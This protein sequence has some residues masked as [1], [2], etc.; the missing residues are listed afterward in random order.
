MPNHLKDKLESTAST[1]LMFVYN[2][3]FICYYYATNFDVIFGQS[4]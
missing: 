4:G 2:V 3:V 1:M